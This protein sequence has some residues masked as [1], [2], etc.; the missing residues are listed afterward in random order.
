MKDKAPWL[1]MVL[2]L[3]VAGALL[4]FYWPWAPKRPPMA[5]PPAPTEPAPPAPVVPPA[6]EE[7]VEVPPA[8]PPAPGQA[9]VLLDGVRVSLDTFLAALGRAIVFQDQAWLDALGQKRLEIEGDAVPALLAVAQG[10]AMLFARVAA[11][12]LLGRMQARASVPVLAELIAS[13]EAFLQDAALRALSRIGG[14][15]AFE[16]IANA[17]P[18]FGDPGLRMRAARAL[19]Q[20]GV[21]AAYAALLALLADPD[22][23]VRAEAALALG[24]RGDPRAIGP[25]FNMATNAVRAET[26]LAALEGAYTL[27]AR[28]LATGQAVDFLDHHPEALRELQRRLAS[29]GVD[30]R[31]AAPYP[32]GFFDAGG[33]PVRFAEGEHARVGIL[34]DPGASGMDLA[35]IA[36]RVFAVSPFD[37]YRDFF[38]LRVIAEYEEDLSRGVPRPRAYDSRGTFLPSGMA[39]SVLDGTFVLR[40]A[41]IKELMPGVTGVTR[42]REAQVTLDSLVHEVG[43][44][45]AQLADEYDDP[46]AGDLGKANLE[47]RDA[48]T[49]KWQPLVQ[50]G[51]LPQGRF[52]R[53]Q[54]V[55]GQDVGTW[56]VPSDGCFMNNQPGDARYC[57]VCQL[58]V[59]DRICRLTGAARPW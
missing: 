57:P 20:A 39:V 27:D 41:L 10:P 25:L 8:Q 23:R 11:V 5:S 26:L 37:R 22:E 48:A 6:P 36:E 9:F 21:E 30:A 4:Y 29:P 19:A 58:E 35:A 38:F 18:T 47:T 28:A 33:L 1:V 59:V 17:I 7:P 54:V 40:F 50:H 13:R 42:G 49:L 46:R 52:L 32:P 24:R 43:H 2:L 53:E 15:Q 14:P 31:F 56:V 12:E 16:A 3:A 51:F 44:A 34:V 45:F 55:N